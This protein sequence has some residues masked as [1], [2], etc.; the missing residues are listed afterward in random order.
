MT[1]RQ[2]REIHGKAEEAR[3]NG[4]FIDALKYCDK[5]TLQYIKDDDLLGLAEVQSSRQST[6]K[7]LYR[8]NGNKNYL[9]L[10]K[11]AALSAVEIAEGSGIKEALAIPYHNLGKYYEEAGE[12]QKAVEFFKKAVLNMRNNPPSMH[13]RP[14]VIAD[15]EGHQYSSEYLAGDKTALEKAEQALKDLEKSGEDKISR[16]NFDV[17]VSGAHLRIVKMLMTDDPETARKHLQKAKEVIDKNPDLKL[18]AD[19][20][21]KLKDLF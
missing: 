6:F 21:K 12:H 2:S 16:Y 9:I 14:G 7:Q 17:W 18:R 20:W 13:N 8:Q 10:E 1:S 4:R 5:A 3:E 11:Y 19:Q 15:I